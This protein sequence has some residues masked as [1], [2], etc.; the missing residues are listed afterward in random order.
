MAAVMLSNNLSQKTVS[1]LLIAANAFNLNF[2]IET[3]QE[4]IFLPIATCE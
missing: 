1:V 4:V 2:I 3:A